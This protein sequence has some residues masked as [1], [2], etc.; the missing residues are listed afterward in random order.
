MSQKSAGGA[1]AA[2]GFGFQDQVATAISVE[3]LAEI[4]GSARWDLPANTALRELWCETQASVDDILVRT[5]EDG[6]LFIQVKKGLKLSKQSGSRF[7]SA[8]DQ[9][10]R[11]FIQSQSEQSTAGSFKRQ[12]DRDKDRIVI[13]TDETASTS[14]RQHFPNVL[15]RL[16]E[17]PAGSFASAAKT[18]DEKGAIETVS[19]LI[20]SGWKKLTGSPPSDEHIRA[21]LGL[22]RVVSLDRAGS[23]TEAR[24]LLASTVLTDPSRA[25]D[26]WNALLK[27]CRELT[28]T[29]S[30]CDTAGLQKVLLDAG[31]RVKAVPSYDGDIR[32]LQNL[33]RDAL[34]LLERHASIRIGTESLPVGRRVVAELRRVAEDRSVLLVGEPGAGK[35]GT[36]HNLVRRLIEEN[37]DV[38]LLAAEGIRGFSLP[39]LQTEF[40]LQHAFADVLKNWPGSQPSFLV[41]DSLDSA[42]GEVAASALRN[43]IE[44]VL[45]G[46]PRWRVLASIRSFDLR[47]GGEYQRLFPPTPVVE[48]EAEF[49]A[50]D[51]HRTSHVN[52]RPFSDAE[53]QEIGKQSSVLAN[54][55]HSA[56]PVLRELLAVPFNLQLAA[57]LLTDGVS[58]KDLT[59]ISSQLELIESYWHQRVILSRGANDGRGDARED[60][61]RR[62]CRAMVRTRSLR[63]ERSTIGDATNS[64]A[65]NEV[66]SAGVLNDDP[67][68][69]T[70]SFSHHTLFDY[71]TARL[72]L[73]HSAS[74]LAS[75]LAGDAELALI[76]R[77]S[78]GFH[79]HRVWNLDSAR[80]EFWKTVFAILRE[81]KVPEIGKLIGPSVAADQ[82][83]KIAELDPLCNALAASDDNA[84]RSAEQALNHLVGA[85]ANAPSGPQ[86]LAGPEAG[87]W[88][89]LAERVSEKLTDRSAYALASLFFLLNERSG[90]FTAEQRAAAGKAAR[91]LFEF[92]WSLPRYDRWLIIRS[93]QSL[94]RTFASEAAASRE[95]LRRVIEE[96][97]LSEHG[98]EELPWLAREVTGLVLA[99]PS[100][101]EQIYQSAF[102]HPLPEEEK[103]E[104]FPSRILGLVSNKRQ[105]FEHGLWQLAE[106][107]P[108]F[109][110]QVPLQG[111][112]AL[113]SA[114]EKYVERRHR[115]FSG[116]VVERTFVFDGITARICA[117]LS[118][119]WDIGNLYVHDNPVRMLDAFSSYLSTMAA[120]GARISELVGIVEILAREN[121]VAAIWRRL[122]G[123]AVQFPD[124][125]GVLIK[126]LLWAAPILT[127]SD[128]TRAAGELLRVIFAKLSAEDR[129]RIERAILSIT[130]EFPPEQKENSEYWRN[131]LLGCLEPEA[132][133]T[134]DAK[135]I[136]NGLKAAG[137]LPTNEPL[138]RIGPVEVGDLSEADFLRI[139][140][141]PV[142]NEVNQKIRSLEEPVKA[143]AQRHTNTVPELAESENV[144][145]ALRGLRSGLDEAEGVHPKQRDHAWGVLADACAAI[146]RQKALSSSTL[147][148]AFVRETLLKAAECADPEYLSE[149]EEQFQRGPAWGSPAARIDAA[150]GLITLARDADFAHADVLGL[151]ERLEQDPVS[152]VRYQIACR[153]TFLNRTAPELMWRL[154]ERE[155]RKE[156]N[157]GV[158]QGTLGTLRSIAG[159]NADRVASLTKE[160][161]TRIQ[162]GPPAGRPV[163]ELCFSIL[164]GLYI[165]QE[166]AT[167]REM[168]EEI[169]A[170]PAEFP[171]QI[172]I[173]LLNLREALGY[174]PA[175]PDDP[176][177]E[178]VRRRSIDLVVRI[179]RTARS[180]IHQF[181]S[182]HGERP[183]Q[184]WS[185]DEKKTAQALGKVMNAV[186]EQVFFASGALSLRLPSTAQQPGLT[187]QQRARFFED[188]SQ[189]I[190]EL[191]QLGFS[192]T[193]HHVLQ[194]LESFVEFDPAG[195]FLNVGRTLKAAAPYGYQFEQL[196]ADVFVRLVERYLADH[197]EIFEQ[198]ADCRKVLIETLDI[199][200]NVGWANA[201]RLTYRLEELFR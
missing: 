79:F 25:G 140:G 199:F 105:D 29:R 124:T 34:S 104:F 49:Q 10:V 5:S 82:A 115:T 108:T 12:L 61:L 102:T 28:E 201:R 146:A 106:C 131:R 6:H 188:T 162:D 157:R 112:R 48:V 133:V 107:F 183:E 200:V 144:F 125:L 145:S 182:E 46:S 169:I 130:A 83:E 166:N 194:T 142:D 167:C 100:L 187:Q 154:L 80:G 109:L 4:Q 110:D 123:S 173:I 120:D 37:R 65:L 126:P 190:G 44:L 176:K 3:V 149:H 152:S 24:T 60:V 170:K 168:V 136:L 71:A 70:L 90:S 11:L 15:K 41:I 165:W 111:I 132:L 178:A 75:Q 2:G 20:S 196:A 87:P 16:R 59:G 181:E 7:A 113:I 94:C 141:V 23:E 193:A 114:L 137:A 26:A 174:G 151:V 138:V 13:V 148:G 160:V 54:L 134:S 92:A 163:E 88:C 55:I 117:D 158:L 155:C 50:D 32:Q 116:E 192:S 91:R 119:S 58:L 99:D 64:Q 180:G 66:L 18:Q 63:V 128:T 101:I 72:V 135:E 36:I 177:A 74:G 103:T 172:S 179:L 9:C 96:Q 129:M 159:P 121:R 73:S 39:S 62:T 195:V 14:I 1:A 22:L 42:R 35:S 84:C 17:S 57:E 21:L 98:F 69:F 150:A 33:T 185:E 164:T 198:R 31:L 161:L 53:L 189:L 175:Q 191:S 56:P 86:R 186:A 77:P 127:E 97:R 156:E 95:L 51:F 68:R 78:L 143:F 52:V 118:H 76:I 197:R 47:Y 122:L 45:R 43:L 153:L 93:I 139:K 85:L 147:L 81:E 171:D 67:K 184:S 40:G 89:Y 27:K 38:V 30:G 8:L 19:Q